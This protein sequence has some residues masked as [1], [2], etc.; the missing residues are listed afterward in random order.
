MVFIGSSPPVGSL[1]L[2]PITWQLEVST[3][4]MAAFINSPIVFK[5]ENMTYE[6]RH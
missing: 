4:Q 2:L 6:W 5:V 3:L 1:D